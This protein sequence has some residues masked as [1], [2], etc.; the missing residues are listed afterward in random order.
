MLMALLLSLMQV[1]ERTFRIRQGRDPRSR[2]MDME[3][4]GKDLFLFVR[5]GVWQAAAGHSMERNG[6]HIMSKRSG[7]YLG[8]DWEW[9]RTA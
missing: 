9:S 4:E 2:D 6:T 7:L 1:L 3:I 5:T 8:S